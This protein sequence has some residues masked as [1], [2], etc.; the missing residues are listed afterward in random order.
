MPFIHRVIHIFIEKYRLFQVVLIK[1]QNVAIVFFR[2]LMDGVIL[3][4]TILLSLLGKCFNLNSTVFIVTR[5]LHLTKTKNA[6]MR[7]LFTFCAPG[8]IRTPNDGSEDRYDIH[9]TTGAIC[10]Y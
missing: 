6:V 7:F 1:S 4:R 8:G 10:K 5:C 3:V 2:N 9:F